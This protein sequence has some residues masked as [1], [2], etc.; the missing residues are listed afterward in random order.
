[1]KVMKLFS[2]TYRYFFILLLGTYSYANIAW[3]ETFHYYGIHENATI[4]W[5]TVLWVSF[6]VWEGNRLLEW[7][8]NKW[9]LRITKQWHPLLVFFL[10]SLPLAWISA[11][12]PYYT[13]AGWYFRKTPEEM[14]IALKLITVFSFRINLFLHSVNALVFYVNRTKQK[15]LEAESMHR[16]QAQANLQSIR[17]QINPHFLFNNLN[18]LSALIIRKSDEANAFVEAFASVYRYILNS[19]EHELVSLREELEFIKPYLFLLEKRYEAGLQVSID[20]PD[21]AMNMEVV[22]AALQLLVENAIKHNVVSSQRP[23]H[24]SIRLDGE[25][26]LV[27]ENT[28]QRKADP[29]ES[30]HIGLDNIS[31]RYRL[32]AGKDIKVMETEGR[33]RVVI[34]LLNSDRA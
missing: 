22:P 24:L 7:A 9:P 5:L 11:M 14:R 21:N 31:S 29:G 26:L 3:L 32:I 23:L 18:V 27:V 30:T 10:L 19:K 17:N 12:I 25:G 8:L 28:L 33:F 16:S 1:M 34:P 15:E 6:L 20:I 2:N 4:E 13:V